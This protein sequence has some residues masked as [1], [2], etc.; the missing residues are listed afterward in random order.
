MILMGK[1]S[2]LYKNFMSFSALMILAINCI[3]I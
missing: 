3:A 1:C 2:T